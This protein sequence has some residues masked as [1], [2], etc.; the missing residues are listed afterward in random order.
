[1]LLRIPGCGSLAAHKSAHRMEGNAEGDGSGVEA[2]GFSR[3]EIA[4]KIFGLQ[5]WVPDPKSKAAP[6]RRRPLAALVVY[7]WLVSGPA[8]VM[9]PLTSSVSILSF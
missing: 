9:L 7:F 8:C 3:T 2:C 5:P 6:E 4:T 1:M